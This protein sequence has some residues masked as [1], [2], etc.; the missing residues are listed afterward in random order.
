[1]QAH[2]T[3][4]PLACARIKSQQACSESRHFPVLHSVRLAE[5]V[6]FLSIS[7]EGVSGRVCRILAAHSPS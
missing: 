2:F 3:W 1:M 4:V 5:E 7:Q 6:L